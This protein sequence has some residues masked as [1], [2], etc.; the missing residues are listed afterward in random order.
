MAECDHMATACRQTISAPNTVPSQPEAITVPAKTL[1]AESPGSAPSATGDRREGDGAG[2][3][4]C[5]WIKCH[6]SK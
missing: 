6:T 3:A 1:N 5:C 2:I 4:S